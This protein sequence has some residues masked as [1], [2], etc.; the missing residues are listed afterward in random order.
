[1]GKL[2][3]VREASGKGIPEMVTL[4]NHARKRV[5]IE[6]LGAFIGSSVLIPSA[7]MAKNHNLTCADLA[8]AL[9]KD[10][11]DVVSATSVIV[12]A[13]ATD[14][15]YCRIDFTVS[16]LSGPMGGYAPGVAQNVMARVGLPLSAADGG[17]G[18]TQGAWNGRIQNLGQ[19]GFAGTV[20]S[21]TGP[22]N[23]GY[24]GATTNTGHVGSNAFFAL[25]PDN[26]QNWGGILDYS[27]RAMHIETEY[28]EAIAK[29]YYDEKPE[30]KYWNGCS[31][32][33]FQ[34]HGIAQKW[35]KDMDGIL[36]I[37][38][39]IQY[40]SF[41]PGE[42]WG[43]VVQRQEL[44]TIMTPAK[45]AAVTRGA[46]AACDALDGITDGIIQDPRVCNID[47]ARFVCGQPDAAS[48]GTQCLTAK[49]AVVFNKIQQGPPGPN[50][51]RRWFG[52]EW[53]TELSASAGDP[54]VGLWTQYPPY[55]IFNDPLFD[56]KTLTEAT[57]DD[58]FVKS[59]EKMRYVMGHDNPDLSQFQKHGGKMI[60][61]HGLADQLIQPRGTYSYYN[62]V[63]ETMGGLDNVR[64]FYRFFPYPGIAHCVGAPFQPNA[65]AMDYSSTGPLFQALVNWVEKGI[66]PGES[67]SPVIATNSTGGTR[68]V[69][70]YPDILSYN[71][72]GSI[73]VASNFTCKPQQVDAF[74]P[75]AGA[76]PYPKPLDSTFTVLPNPGKLGPPKDLRDLNPR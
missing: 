37:A 74:C 7:V 36:A 48:L 10:K 57:Y 3:S 46:I 52:A 59:N 9:L 23:A 20:G 49:E 25:N 64:S 73:F 1:M 58:Y 31:L 72:S 69:C 61:T 26:T 15:T 12:P 38:P 8:G 5:L 21:V 19:G 68:P 22:T 66:A 13:T 62:K 28:S 40:D 11:K 60:V 34:G 47:A 4:T 17:S 56:Y 65:P 76:C 54:P 71:G 51:Q 42:L 18:G 63:L 55:F 16:E 44:G 50:G 30:Y 6:L 45:M 70:A 53:G 67:S 29:I 24:V 14:G 43:N 41:F 39:A 75:T 35:P 27:F 32:G 33:G 2:R